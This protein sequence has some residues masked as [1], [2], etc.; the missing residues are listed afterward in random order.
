[1]SEPHILASRSED[2]E[3]RA[4]LRAGWKRR[5]LHWERLQEEGCACFD[6]GDLAGAARAWRRASWVAL[7]L[8]PARDPRQ[9][10]TLANRAHIDRLAGREARARARFARAGQ[11]WGNADDFIAGMTIARRA[12]SSLFHLRMEALHWSTYEDNLRKRFRAFAAET[13]DALEALG[14]GEA[15]AC[16]LHSRWRGEK[17]SIF[18]D[19][20]KFLS[21]ALLVGGGA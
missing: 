9:A 11:I 15:V 4:A 13:A 18:D 5:D 14:R 17:P 8:L 2:T 19:T 1:M 3:M 20:R 10:T 21:A 16:R 7:L 12:R 6:K